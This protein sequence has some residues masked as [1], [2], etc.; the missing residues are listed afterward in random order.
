MEPPLRP[1]TVRRIAAEFDAVV[2]AERAVGPEF[3]TLWLDAPAAPPLRAR[4]FADH[5]FGGDL[6][7]RLL[8]G[9]AALQRLRLLAGPGADL[10]LLRP[11]GEIGVGF[12]IAHRRHVATD[13]DLTAQRLPV[14]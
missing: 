2:Q 3:E 5:V 11:R 6:G 4:H 8:E 7:D 14:K 12:L 10:R 13:A 1:R 9:K